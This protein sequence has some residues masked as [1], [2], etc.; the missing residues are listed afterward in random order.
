L[1]LSTI[2]E[3]SETQMTQLW[4]AQTGTLIKS[5]ESYAPLNGGACFSPDGRYL[6]GYDTLFYT[7]DG[8]DEASML[9]AWDIESEDQDWLGCQIDC[10]ARNGIG[11]MAFTPD[12]KHLLWSVF[13]Y[14]G[15]QWG[16]YHWENL[17]LTAHEN[18]SDVFADIPGALG[19]HFINGTGPFVSM[20]ASISFSPDG[21]LIHSHDRRDNR[22]SLWDVETGA[23][24]LLLDYDTR[25][26]GFLPGNAMIIINEENHIESLLQIET[27]EQVVL[28]ENLMWN[29]SYIFPA[30]LKGDLLVGRDDA[31]SVHFY[32]V[33][34]EIE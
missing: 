17:D 34:A 23:E 1:S 28:F 2:A 20:V 16:S 15:D 26:L 4:D 13:E 7:C 5:F 33:P 14:S 9:F 30:T 21:T 19:E 6:A 3:D 18:G 22:D 32:G 10:M 25:I 12:S 11:G 24:K 31:S 29:G 27:G 8:C